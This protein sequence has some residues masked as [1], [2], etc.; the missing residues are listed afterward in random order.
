MVTRILIHWDEKFQA[1]A[2]DETIERKSGVEK[3]YFGS[4]TESIATTLDSIHQIDMAGQQNDIKADNRSLWESL[5][6]QLK[7]K[8]TQ[9]EIKWKQQSQNTGLPP[10]QMYMDTHD[11]L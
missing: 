11:E 1:L 3:F 5:S 8:N 9:E 4:L 7:L 6:N 2:E 10:I